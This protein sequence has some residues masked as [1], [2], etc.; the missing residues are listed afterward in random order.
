MNLKFFTSFLLL[1]LLTGNCFCPPSKE[2]LEIVDQIGQFSNYHGLA[3]SVLGDQG[4]LQSFPAKKMLDQ[5]IPEF[6]LNFH[7]QKSFVNFDLFDL[8]DSKM[9]RIDTTD[10]GD[11]AGT[12]ALPEIQEAYGK[13]R[14][15]ISVERLK[16]LARSTKVVVHPDFIP[17]VFFKRIQKKD[18]YSKIRP[19][20]KRSFVQ[21]KYLATNNGAVKIFSEP[22]VPLSNSILFDRA[23]K[24]SLMALSSNICVSFDTIFFVEQEID[25]ATGKAFTKLRNGDLS[26][27]VPVLVLAV[28]GLNLAY[29]VSKNGKIYDGKGRDITEILIENMWKVVLESL[30]IRGVRYAFFPAIGLG[31]FAPKGREGR[32]AKI[33]FEKL[34]KLLSKE[35]Q[36]DFDGIFLNP[37]PNHSK[38][39][40][41]II[42]KQNKTQGLNDVLINYPHDVMFAAI[43]LSKAGIRCGLLDPS[44]ADVIWGVAHPGQY[45]L[46]GDYVFEEH[47]GGTSTACL[48][49]RGVFPEGYTQNVV[50]V[51]TNLA[52]KGLNHGQKSLFR[53]VLDKIKKAF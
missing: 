38:L 35:Y 42:S 48:N 41:Q 19:Q 18:F 15:E 47:I 14:L 52:G 7:N 12:R 16:E 53:V 4:I 17:A 39:L 51:R 26:G 36:G 28:P 50:E 5:V 22:G 33:Y 45:C 34:A 1:L 20:E 43:E 23:M 10:Q 30:K 37:K 24:T 31:A 29:G 6:A 11:L 3:D 27:N 8:E 44:D 25:D 40:N 32:I 46:Y 21:I 13:A 2:V 9:V 49:S